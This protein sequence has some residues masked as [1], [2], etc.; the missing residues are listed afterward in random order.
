MTKIICFSDLHGQ[1]SKKLTQ[2][3]TNNP[4]D[5]LLF[6]GDI[7]CNNFDTGE[8]FLSW[9]NMLPYKDKVI[10]FG[11]HDGNYEYTL[12]LVRQ[13]DN[14]YILN[15]KSIN[16]QGIKIFGSPYSLPFL[17]WYFMKTEKELKILYEEIPED[18]DILI[19]HCG[20]FGVLDLTVDGIV[21]GSISL[22]NRIS[23]LKNLKYNIFGHIH[24]SYGIKII[25][26]VN[27]INASVLDDKYKLK[28]LPV[29]VEY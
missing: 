20:P 21:T 25:D 4:G 3:F 8:K 1:Y 26:G 5:L 2:W 28:N 9:I 10:I 14:I 11:N 7:Q 27:Y 24:E 22:A 19:T 12:D 13:Y 23:K 6:A 15:H 18:T 16:I 29:V 17:D